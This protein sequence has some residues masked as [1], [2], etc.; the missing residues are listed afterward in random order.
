[1]YTAKV[2]VEKKRLWTCPKCKRRFGRQGQSHS[3][4]AFPLERHFE[5]KPEGKRLYQKLK[6]AAKNEL[7]PFR[8]ESLE[9][10]IHFETNFAF[11]GVKIFKNKI[12]VDF[13]LSWK[14]TNNRIV[15]FTPMSAHR[16]LYSVDVMNEED[17]DPELLEWLKEARNKV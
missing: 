13:S 2:K 11:A 15:R 4:K 16:Y 9:C 10:C 3:C 14:I 8:V 1:M 5:N 7:G 17:V 6:E 12:R